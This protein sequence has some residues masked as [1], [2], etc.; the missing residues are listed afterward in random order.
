MFQPLHGAFGLES[1]EGADLERRQGENAPLQTDD[2]DYDDDDADDET[3]LRRRRH[4]YN[5]AARMNKM[6]Q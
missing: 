2:G 6:Q 1:S 3:D 5:P 4:N